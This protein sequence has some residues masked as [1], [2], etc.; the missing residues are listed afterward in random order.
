MRQPFDRPP[1]QRPAPM[2]TAEPGYR[3][4][5]R[6]AQARANPLTGRF[7]PAAA[8]SRMASPP[9]SGAA[10]CPSCRHL[11]VGLAQVVG[12]DHARELAALRA[13]F[14]HPRAGA[15]AILFDPNTMRWIALHGRAI[16]VYADSAR[17]LR[18][19][20]ATRPQVAM[21]RAP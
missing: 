2:P 14:N 13:E 11:A 12:E 17:S 7:Q 18:D 21:H 8:A 15:W 9:E 16:A 6:D 10:R 20:I 5:P 4:P 19:Q 3:Q 1:A